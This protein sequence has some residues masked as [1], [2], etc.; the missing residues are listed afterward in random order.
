MGLCTEAVQAILKYG[1]EVLELHRI[2]SVYLLCNPAFGR[3]MQKPGMTHEG[4]PSVI[5]NQGRAV[6]QPALRHRDELLIVLRSD[7]NRLL[8]H[9]DGFHD[10]WYLSLE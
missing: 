7:P 2:F 4:H 3:I 6:N 9:Q 1:Y 8:R 10:A 5:D